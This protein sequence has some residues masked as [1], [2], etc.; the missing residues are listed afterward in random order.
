MKNNSMNSSLI[1]NRF[2]CPDTPASK[3]QL[4]SIT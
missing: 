3:T 2:N 1:E 4:Q